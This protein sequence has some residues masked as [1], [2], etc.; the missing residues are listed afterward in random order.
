MQTANVEV[1]TN[2]LR[3]IQIFCRIDGDGGNAYCEVS[4]RRNNNFDLARDAFGG[5]DGFPLSQF[6]EKR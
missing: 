5:D 3:Y 4:N 1:I 6:C 2:V